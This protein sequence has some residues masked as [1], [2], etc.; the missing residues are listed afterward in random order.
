MRK[1][2]YNF[3]L[4]GLEYG[5]MRGLVFSFFKNANSVDKLECWFQEH[6]DIRHAIAFNSARSALFT[7]MQELKKI[8]EYGNVVIPGFSC[9]VVSNS[10]RAAGLEVRYADIDPE[11]LSPSLQSID[12]LIDNNTVAIVIQ[13]VFGFTDENVDELR[14]R[15]PELMIIEDCAHSIGGHYG[16]GQLTGTKGDFAFFSFEQSKLI[17]CWTGG[18]L[19]GNSELMKKVRLRRNELVRLTWLRNLQDISALVLYYFLYDKRLVR[20]GKWLIKVPLKLLFIKPSMT[21]VERDGGF[22]VAEQYQLEPW[23]AQFLL[24][25]LANL[26]ERLSHRRHLVKT[27]IQELELSNHVVEGAAY[28]RLLLMTNDRDELISMCSKNGIE[29]GTWFSSPVHPCDKDYEKFG[30]RYGACP[31][32]ESLSKKTINLPVGLR[33]DESD[34]VKICRILKDCGNWQSSLVE[35]PQREYGT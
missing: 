27:Y 1:L 7:L 4:D 2:E 24:G 14:K 20:V 22:E 5:D 25:Q 26:E 15:Y 16:D 18:I 13:H 28:L 31:I 19:I 17:T 32:A 11:T 29:I 9:V 6:F 34:I 10:I 30:Y 21:V 3:V 8:N 23:K 33:L 12:S 35:L